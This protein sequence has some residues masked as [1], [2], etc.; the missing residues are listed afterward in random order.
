MMSAKFSTRRHIGK[1][2]DLRRLPASASHMTLRTP[3]N[4]VSRFQW[5]LRKK[6]TSVV[7]F[8]PELSPDANAE[9]ISIP[10]E[11]QQVCR[12]IASDGCLVYL[13]LTVS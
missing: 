13:L 4:S 9:G 5:Y 11:A 12:D 6:D 3:P 8:R 1:L 10:I 7:R 2:L